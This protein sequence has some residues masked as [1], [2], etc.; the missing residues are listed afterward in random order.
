[1]LR[2]SKERPTLG[3]TLGMADLLESREVLLLVSG[4]AKCGPLGRLLAGRITTDFP[5]S[6]L[7]L[8]P[9]S[10]PAGRVCCVPRAAVTTTRLARFCASTARAGRST[11]LGRERLRRQPSRDVTRISI[12]AER[13]RADVWGAALEPSVGGNGFVAVARAESIKDHGVDIVAE[14]VDRAIC[15]H[16]VDPARVRGTEMI[17]I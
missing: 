15:E 3:L 4:E 16:G 10:H 17:H 11:T 7:H 12:M 9:P 13:R 6:I 14:A 8:H 1:M 5:A 2:Q